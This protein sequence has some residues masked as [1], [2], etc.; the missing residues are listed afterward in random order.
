[1]SA[2]T[3]QADIESLYG[4]YEPVGQSA[5]ESPE[6]L[7]EISPSHFLPS[8]CNDYFFTALSWAPKVLRNAYW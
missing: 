6:R 3:S 8:Y 5:K 7:W 1:M 2:L 4:V